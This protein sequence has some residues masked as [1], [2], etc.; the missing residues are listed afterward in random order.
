MRIAVSAV[1]IGWGLG[2]GCTSPSREQ[3]RDRAVALT[4]AQDTARH[5]WQHEVG[6]DSVLLHG[7]TTV[8]WVSP[9]SWMAT[10]APQAAVSVLRGGRIVGV[11]W[12]MGG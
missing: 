6:V 5:Q 8:V 1:L 12:I 4:T 7:D 11:R 10:D 9:R 3:E 2:L